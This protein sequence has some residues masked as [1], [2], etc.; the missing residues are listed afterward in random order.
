MSQH[1]NDDDTFLLVI[2][3]CVAVMGGGLAVAWNVMS[4]WLLEHQVLVDDRHAAVG[5]PGGVGLDVPRVVLV[6]AVAV[7]L[8]VVL[9]SRV[10]ASRQDER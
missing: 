3:G 9:I 4:G 10:R 5:L 6:V 7:G 1:S 8:V 2:L